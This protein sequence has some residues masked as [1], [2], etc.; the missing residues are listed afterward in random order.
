MLLTL[1]GLVYYSTLSHT[2]KIATCLS[3]NS[4]LVIAFKIVIHLEGQGV[5]KIRLFKFD[6]ITKTF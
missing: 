3:F 6:I 1:P 4:A 2:E 5:G